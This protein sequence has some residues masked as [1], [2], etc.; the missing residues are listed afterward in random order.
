L[1]QDVFVDLNFKDYSGA[2][3]TRSVA[4]FA[5]LFLAPFLV[6]VINP[7]LQP[8]N[9]ADRYAVVVMAKITSID[10]GN[11]TVVATVERVCQ[12]HFAPT[13]LRITA[14]D[15]AVRGL[16]SLSQGQRLVAYIGKKVKG[17]EG[18]LLFYTGTW[19]TGV[20]PDAAKPGAWTWATVQ[21]DNTM[22]G[23]FNGDPERLG[24]L[25]TEITEGRGYFPCKPYCR[26]HEDR[27]IGKLDAPVRGVALADLDHDGRLDIVAT[28]NAGVKVWLQRDGLRFDD[29]TAALGLAGVPAASVAVADLDGDGK[30]DLLLDGALWSGTGKGFVRSDRVPLIPGLIS[31]TLADLDGDGWADVLAATAT[32]VRI[33]LNPG[34]SNEA[35]SD[36]TARFGLDRAECGAGQGGL[37]ANG[38]WDGDGRSDL[39]VAVGKG[40]LLIRDR[41]GRFQPRVHELDLGLT[42]AAD[43]E[44]CGGA[45]FAPIWRRDAISLLVPRHAG[46]ALAIDRAGAIEDA[47]GFCNETSEPSDRQLWTVAE[48]LNA[49][50]EI[51]LY[52]ASGSAGSSD[53]FHLNRGAGSFMRPMKYIE[54]VFPG[55]AH[56]A[57]SWGVAV[58]DVDG[59]GANDL[60]LGDSDGNVNVL[61]NAALEERKDLDES[62]VPDL[63][64]LALARTLAVS[65]K[66]LRG[67]VGATVTLTDAQGRQVAQRRF[68]ANTVAGSWSG[69][70]LLLTIRE[71]GAYVL[72]LRRTDGSDSV[73]RLTVDAQLAK[74]TAVEFE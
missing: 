2:I 70:P 32:G 68:G 33:Y 14:S 16:F 11:R 10:T 3:M 59:D 73:K 35:F 56:K 50:G 15:G 29:A 21:N 5:L 9:L 41:D 28:A 38:D 1:T 61:L 12:G 43:G 66:S 51:D 23:I 6:A 48:D 52:T 67:V 17:R 58:G 25:M 64:K 34:K 65:A 40:L 20:V 19:Q 7:S 42:P 45:V 60:L 26:F 31:A 36:A 22:A 62:A 18:D 27:V 37:V 13:E 4:V 24:E 47:I 8:V 44:R 63:S 30:A 39:F 46:F 57:G 49:D 54:G 53:V 74:F 55:P 71:P 72:S 69:G